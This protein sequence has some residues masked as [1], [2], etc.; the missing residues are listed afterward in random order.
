MIDTGGHHAHHAADSNT[1]SP[2][3]SLPDRVERWRTETLPAALRKLGKVEQ[4]DEF[5]VST[6]ADI[7]DHDFLRDVSLPGEFPFTSWLYPTPT[8]FHGASGLRRAGR[9]SGFGT[10]EDIREQLEAAVAGGTPPGPEYSLGS[11]QPAWLGLR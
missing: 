10:S 5:D 4:V 2:D 6:P 9:Y 3:N 7:A 1:L 8:P 11:A